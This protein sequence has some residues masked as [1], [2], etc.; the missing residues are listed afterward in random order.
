[1]P[2]RDRWYA[3]LLRSAVL[4]IL[5]RVSIAHERNRLG[6]MTDIELLDI[7][8]RRRDALREARQPFW[9]GR[10]EA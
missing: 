4:E 5:D 1:M 8:I 6:K 3:R 2:I 7:G 9:K 10:R